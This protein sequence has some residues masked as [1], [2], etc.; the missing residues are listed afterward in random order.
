V[1]TL[2]HPSHAGISLPIIVRIGITLQKLEKEISPNFHFPNN[3]TSLKWVILSKKSLKTM[4][5]NSWLPALFYVA[6]AM[7]FS[8]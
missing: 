3:P 8:G 1:D 4:G 2:F 5:I 7:P 6:I